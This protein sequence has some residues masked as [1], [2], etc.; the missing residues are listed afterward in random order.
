[1][2]KVFCPRYCFGKQVSALPETTRA[3]S[4]A[5]WPERSQKESPISVSGQRCHLSDYF[6][7]GK[8]VTARA[9]PVDSLF[10]NLESGLSHSTFSLT[11]KSVKRRLAHD[12]Q[13]AV[14][15]ER[16]GVKEAI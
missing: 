2:P 1:M 10:T 7:D 16:R 15:P 4:A 12:Q 8:P 5:A 6:C 3:H 11:L 9:L 14:F 13:A